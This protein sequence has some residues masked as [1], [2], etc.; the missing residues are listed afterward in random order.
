[1][2]EPAT[3]EGA[4]EVVC[5]RMGVVMEPDGSVREAEG[6]LNPGAVRDRAGD[7]LLYPRMVGPGNVS[8]IGLA[9]ARGD[10][11]VERVGV[12]LAPE[13]DYEL[14]SLPGGHGCEDA[15]VTYVPLLDR[16]LMAYTAFGPQGAR[17]AVAVSA[18]AHT[19][20]RLG[21][22]RFPL[23]EMN[24]VDNKDAAFFPEPVVSPAGV[25]SLAFF[26]RPMRPET[27]NGQTPIAVM[28]ALPPHLREAACIA[29]VPLEDV[30]RDIEAVC[31][32]Q[33]SIRFLEPGDDWGRLKNGAG[34]PP[35]RTRYG[36]LSVFH[37]VDAVDGPRGRS[38][39]YSAGIVI[40]DIDRPHRVIYRSPRPLLVPETAAERF[41]TVDDV[42][43]PTG[44][45][46]VAADAFDVY[47]GAADAKVS[48]VRIEVHASA[49]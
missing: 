28:S 20:Q 26:H 43:F 14:R 1:M 5:R 25:T 10:A 48:R 13:R 31:A 18:D 32:P 22:I 45:D 19:W 33:E 16:Y 12:V 11:P 39:S 8:C 17:I 4:L 40:N 29:Y 2:G 34:T 46:P 6:V 7:L 27:I 23:A 24:A 35:V 49:R 42:V 9:R 21:L 47:Y 41:G 38:L 44:I 15:R 30:C 36:W 37:G 3:L